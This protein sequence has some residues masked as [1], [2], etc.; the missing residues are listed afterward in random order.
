MR[1]YVVWVLCYFVWFFFSS[2]RRHTRCALV[3]GVQTCALPISI[4]LGP[5]CSLSWHPTR[6]GSQFNVKR[7]VTTN[8]HRE[9]SNSSMLARSRSTFSWLSRAF[10]RLFSRYPIPSG[11]RISRK[12]RNLS[13]RRQGLAKLHKP[14]HQSLALERFN[15]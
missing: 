1:V 14:H 12:S 15:L 5:T 8:P 13:W 9:R 10:P 2:R 6:I 11:I 4:E 3:T 7:Q